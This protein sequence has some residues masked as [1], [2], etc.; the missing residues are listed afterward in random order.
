MDMAVT[1]EVTVM[2]DMVATGDTDMVMA[3]TAI[4]TGTT[5]IGTTVMVTAGIGTVA[6]MA[7][8]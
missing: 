8:E 4:I 6:G 1:T 7:T 3:V 5:D 2:A